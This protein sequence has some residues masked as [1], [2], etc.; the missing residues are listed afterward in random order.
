MIQVLDWLYEN[1]LRHYPLQENFSKRDLSN[2]YQLTTN[3]ILDAQFVLDEEADVGITNIENV[4]DSEV[5]FTI[6]EIGEITVPKNS[7]FP[8]YVRTENGSLVV[9]GIGVKDI[10]IGSFNFNTL[11]FED[12]TISIFAD[13]WLGVSSLTFDN[14]DPID[15]NLEFLEGYQFELFTNLQNIRFAAGSM[16]GKQIGC[17]QFSNYPDD[18][19]DI[20]S[21]INGVGPDGNKEMF[22]KAGPG[23][24]VWD[25]PPNHR[26][27]VGFAFT[28]QNDVCGDIPPFPV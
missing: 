14:E 19:D 6:S 5:V 1:E 23:F 28:S 7:S 20:I 10:P 24:V 9:F 15:G 21:S 17:L 11:L 18:C 27:Y 25:D 12:S 2:T 26:I 16:Y 8:F 22:L 3:V 4:D 13:A